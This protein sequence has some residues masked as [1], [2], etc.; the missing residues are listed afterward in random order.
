MLAISVNPVWGNG[1]K[2][3]RLTHHWVY[4]RVLGE[5]NDE[6]LG[7]INL[8]AVKGPQPVVEGDGDG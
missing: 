7:R 3:Y 6:Q 2:R 5:D 8:P 1:C 4:L